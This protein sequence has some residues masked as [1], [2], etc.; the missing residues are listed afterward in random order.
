MKNLTLC[1]SV[2]DVNPSN[3][4]ASFEDPLISKIL[5]MH[6]RYNLKATFFVPAN[7]LGKYNL[8]DYKEWCQFF[9][10]IDFIEVAAHGYYHDF[11]EIQNLNGKEFS[12]MSYAKSK[13]RNTLIK[14]SFQHFYKKEIKGWKMPGWEFNLES[15]KAVCEDFQY[16]YPHPEH[17]NIYKSVSKNARILDSSNT[18]DIQGNIL[19]SDLK[20]G[21]LI[22]HS[23]VDGNTNNNRWTDYNFAK[24]QLNLLDIFQFFKVTPSFIEQA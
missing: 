9:D 12:K 7:F 15:L 11:E 22:L 3:V 14:Q 6:Q 4:A 16:V 21:P 20:P 23:H 19:Y 8:R 18:F 13:E 10:E 2:D 1:L 24:L 17:I 5:L